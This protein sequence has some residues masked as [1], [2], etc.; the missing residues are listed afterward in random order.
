MVRVGGKTKE[1]GFRYHNVW[2]KKKIESAKAKVTVTSAAGE[3]RED[4]RW[5]GEDHNSYMKITEKLT[6]K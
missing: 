5:E 6:Q 1:R 3:N 4:R 2:G